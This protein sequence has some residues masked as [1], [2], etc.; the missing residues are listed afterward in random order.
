MDHFLYKDGVLHAEDVSLAEIAAAVGTPVYVYSTAT[1]LR[2]FHLFD[3]ALSGMDHLVCY[4]M[5]ANSNQAV[6]RTLAQA[7]AGMDVVSGGEYR[8]AKAA[9]VPGDR[10]VF[11]GVGKTR[12]E[13][14]LAL[15]GGIRQFNV[16]SEPEMILLDV[17]ARELGK[18]API[19]IRVN[20]DVDA[21]THAKIATGK[22]ENKFGIPIARARDVYAM[23]AKLPGLE[24]IGIDVHIG[25]QLTDLAPFEQAYG[26]VAELTEVLRADGHNIRRLDLG[27]GLGIPYERSNTAPPLPTD[28]GAMVQRTLGHLGCEVEIEPGRLIAG[29][30]GVL[31]S[32]VIYFKSGEGRDFLILD[33]AMNDLIRPAMYDAWHDIVPLN[34]PAP[35]AEP[36]PVDIV[37]PVCESGDTFAKQRMMPVLGSG[38]LVAFRSAGA[39]GAVM[40]SEYNSRPL[41]PEVLVNGDQFAVIR[42]RPS[43]DE[44]INRDTIPEWL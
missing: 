13:I 18:V 17:V 25:S 41:I 40:S 2:H 36:R 31:V 6:L 23:A 39:Y 28:Y 29:N 15:T 44:M 24:I 14:E 16:E 37:G 22:S 7:G 27:G 11:S 1:L 43:F 26:K 32:E 5:K 42:P 30:A 35:G 33:A 3:D 19:T 38:D 4:A 21:K 8:R 10:I 34:E 20:P 9:G 12:E